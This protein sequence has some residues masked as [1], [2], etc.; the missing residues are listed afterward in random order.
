ML[1][2]IVGA[3]LVPSICLFWRRRS[4][5]HCASLPAEGWLT[6]VRP[7]DCEDPLFGRPEDPTLMIRFS[8]GDAERP[9]SSVVEALRCLDVFCP[10]HDWLNMAQILLSGFPTVC[11]GRMSPGWLELNLSARSMMGGMSS[12]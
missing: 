2:T 12:K 3:R 11:G 9:Q 6:V 4:E 10:N 7:S 5:T 1:A 8:R